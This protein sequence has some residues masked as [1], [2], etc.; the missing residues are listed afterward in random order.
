MFCPARTTALGCLRLPVPPDFLL[1]AFSNVST[2]RFFT[3]TVQRASRVGGAAL[4]LPPEVELRLLEPPMSR[5]KT[6]TRTV[7]LRTVEIEGP[8]GNSIVLSGLVEFMLNMMAGKMAIQIPSYMDLDHDHEAR[9]ARLKVLDPEERKQ[10]E[11]W[12]EFTLLTRILR[13]L[14]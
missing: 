12:G 14:K 6:I 8:L 3:S 7:P 13:V 11:M 1:P 4:S 5:R 2:A 10:R 9:K